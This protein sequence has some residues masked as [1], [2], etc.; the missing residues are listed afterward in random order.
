MCL[1]SIVIE[2]PVTIFYPLNLTVKHVPK[3]LI[4]AVVVL[5]CLAIG[6]TINYFLGGLPASLYGLL[7]FAAVLS[8]GIIDDQEVGKVVAKAIYYMPVVF[9]PVCVGVM[10]YL[11]LFAEIGW[12]ILIIG[13]GTTVFGV[14][15]I[16][17][18]S[19]LLLENSDTELELP[20]E[21]PQR[22]QK[23]NSS[24]PGNNDA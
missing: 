10:Q 20:A 11:G 17:F 16:A 1:S 3:Y 7:L 19:R 24:P 4:T 21:A 6:K 9:L 2:Q 8:T 14:V 15:I 22:S 18:S 5:F 12:K 23:S 13:V